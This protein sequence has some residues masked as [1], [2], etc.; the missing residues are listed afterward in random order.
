[1]AGERKLDLPPIPSDY[2]PPRRVTREEY[3]RL[4]EVLPAKY[5]YHNGL[6][7][8]RQYPPGSHWAMA[9][10]TEAHARIIVRVLAFLE[11]N[12]AN[13][14]CQVYPSDMKLTVETKDYYP[15][16]FVVCN[17]PMQPNR[18]QLEDA[19]LVCEVRSQST[20]DFDKG[21]KF[22]AYKRLSSLSEY[23]ILDNRR[24]QATLFQKGEDGVWRYL[25]IYEGAEVPLESVGLRMPLAQI[26]GGLTLDPDPTSSQSG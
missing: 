23:L 4:D 11:G 14:P 8:P 10:G 20:A 9:G 16:A 18:R 13:D 5:E 15:D 26:Y 7:Y 2:E 6:M 12:L 1:M 3:Q 21:D 24:A 19:T 17:E 25:T 22:E